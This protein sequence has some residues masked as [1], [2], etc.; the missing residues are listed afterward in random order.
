MWW[1]VHLQ[2]KWFLERVCRDDDASLKRGSQ[3]HWN[4][5][6]GPRICF[7]KGEQHIV[8]LQRCFDDSRVLDSNLHF[9]QPAQC[10]RS[11][12]GLVRRTGSA[13]L[14]SFVFQYGETCGDYEWRVGVSNLNVVSILPNP[15]S[16]NVPVQGDL[17]R[18]LN[19]R[20][21]HFPE[22]VRVSKAREDVGIMRKISLGHHSMTIHDLDSNGFG[23]AG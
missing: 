17:L 13:D 9:F 20:F 2:A 19:K 21:E 7:W 4:K 15:F 11:N 12:F 6:I 22:D 16:I 3:N 1:I 5:C 18:S 23:H 10:P 14:R 8:S